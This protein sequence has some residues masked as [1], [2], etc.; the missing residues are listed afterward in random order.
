MSRPRLQLILSPAKTMN[1]APYAPA[2]AAGA[3]E[4]VGLA[5]ANE[6]A[7]LLGKKSQAALK[8]LLGVSDGLA[9]ENFR[10]FAEWADAESRQACVAYDGMAYAKL[11]A[12]TLDADALRVG[13]RKLL[14]LSG[15]WGP[16]RPLD[17]IK[18]YRLEMACKKLPEP[19]RDLAAYW[20]ETAT[21]TL[22]DGYAEDGDRVLVNVASD[23]YAKA[24]D[25]D[26]V[27]EAGV[28]VVK[29]DFFQG[30]KRAAA[31]HLKHGRGLVTRY[32][33]QNDVDTLEALQKFDLEDYAYSAALSDDDRVVFSR[34]APPAKKPAAKKAKKK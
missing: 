10:R 9:A 15:L 21:A 29:V 16:V 34:S 8:G 14:I 18:A 2:D 5:R 28:K 22:L 24:I 13:Q 27:A 7:A 1:L 11:D 19:H 31:V 3:T 12:R 23:E 4:A 25:V 6:L 20:R 30:G 32:V 26:A 17:A 33:F